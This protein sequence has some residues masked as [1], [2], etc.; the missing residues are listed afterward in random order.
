VTIF[1]AL[2]SI[3]VVVTVFLSCN[4]DFPPVRL[5]HL[6]VRNRNTC[7]PIIKQ[8]DVSYVIVGIAIRYGMDGPDIESRYGRDFPHPSE[9]HPT[10]LTMDTGSFPGGGVD[11]PPLLPLWAFVTCSRVNFTYM[12]EVYFVPDIYPAGSHILYVSFTG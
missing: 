2:G 7:G 9:A 10:S 1:L 8:A 5:S 11:H 3:F 6:I 12:P 4:K